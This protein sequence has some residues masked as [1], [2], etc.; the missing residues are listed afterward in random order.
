MSLPKD[1]APAAPGSAKSRG[2]P[3]GTVQGITLRDRR[4]GDLGWLLMRQA[5][6]Y[7]DEFGYAPV[8]ETYVAAGLPPFL[9]NEDPEKDRVW[10]AEADGP[11]VGQ[12][13][14]AARPGPAGAMPPSRYVGALAQS[15]RVGAIAIQHDPER[16]D[17]A[18]LRWYLVEKE[19]R[20][21]GLGRRLVDEALAFCRQAGYAGVHLWTCSDLDAARRQYERARFRLVE[22]TECPW[23][24]SVRQQRWELG[25]A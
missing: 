2:G 25:L 17:W 13:V 3:S 14:G 6:L 15:R 12:A 19:A 4:P 1:A 22:E 18:K 21:Q 16:D 20:G 7:A 5:E 23:K 10:I 9:D 8:F 24:P 11:D